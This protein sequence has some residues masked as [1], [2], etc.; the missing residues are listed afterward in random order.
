[1]NNK[2]KYLKQKVNRKLECKKDKN[3]MP[4]KDCNGCPYKDFKPNESNM[5][6]LK[7]KSSKLARL[8]RNRFSLFTDDLEHC[9]ICGR[10]R[11][12]IHEVFFGRNRQNSIIYKLCIPLCFDCHYKMH[13]DIKLQTLYH[14]KGQALFEETYPDLEFE[15]IFKINY[16][17]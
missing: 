8:E 9:I 15:D 5:T 1:M 14:K 3:R 7:R 4:F 11:D 16:L 13:N 2:C 10:K 17:D 6:K 12:H